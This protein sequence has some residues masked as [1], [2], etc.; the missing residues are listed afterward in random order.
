MK[1]KEYIRQLANFLILTN[2]SMS[3][4]NLAAHLNWNKFRT[5]NGK[6]Y[7]GKRGTYVLVKST[8]KWL[9]KINKIDEAKNVAKAFKTPDGKYA[10][11]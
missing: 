5:K 2:T 8:W 3:A 9:E 6:K 1:N 7:K 4:E 10:Y 11:E